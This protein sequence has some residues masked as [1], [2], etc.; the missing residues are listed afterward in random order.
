MVLVVLA[1]ALFWPSTVTAP[2]EAIDSI[3]V[4]P[5][6]NQSGDPDLDYVSDGMT[7]GIISRLSQLSSLNKVISNSSVRQYKGKEVDAGTVAQEVDVRAVVMGNLATQG[8]T[9]RVYVELIDARNNSTLWGETYTRPRSQLNEVEEYISKQIADA[10]GLQ[11]TGEEEEQLGKRYTDNSE[12]HEAYLKGRSALAQGNE[13]D[14]LEAVGYFEEAIERDAEYSA[15]YAALALTYYWLHQRFGAMAAE[16]AMPRAEELAN[17]ALEID[18]TLAE[19]LT[20]RASIKRSY[21]WDWEGAERDYK[22]ALELDPSSSLTHGLYA[23]WMTVMGRHEEAISLARRALQLDPSSLVQRMLLQSAFYSARRYDEAAEQAHRALEI[24]PTYIPAY[25]ALDG[26]YESTGSYQEAVA[27]RQES[28]RLRGVSEDKIAAFLA[29]YATSGKDGYWRWI[30]DD[31]TERA[32]Q[33]YVTPTSFAANHANLGEKD[34]AFEWLEKAY[35]ERRGQ[36]IFLKSDN[37]WDPLRDDPR[38][39]DLLRR[40]NLEP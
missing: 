34:Q 21:Y 31:R 12:A 19:A 38:F 13:G 16:E 39:T 10:L 3:A 23:F 6:E 2:E 17:K 35:E 11:L 40:M 14:Y 4:L 18:S 33:E 1:L 27:A 32:K 28:M 22:Q 9:L 8:D 7:Q 30:L 15:A 24:D 36:L 29:A 20:I 37:R 5:F 25:S 26:I